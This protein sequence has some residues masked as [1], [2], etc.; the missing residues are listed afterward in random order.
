MNTKRVHRTGHVAAL[1]WLLVALGATDVAAQ[2]SIDVHD[3]SRVRFSRADCSSEEE[4]WLDLDVSGLSGALYRSTEQ[5]MLQGRST[6]GGVVC[7]DPFIEAALST[8]FPTTDLTPNVGADRYLDY[9]TLTAAD[10]LGDETCGDVGAR[11]TN[12][13]LCW[14]ILD[15]NLDRVVTSNGIALS[16]DTALPVAPLLEDVLAE[17]GQV[18]FTLRDPADQG[19]AFQARVQYRPCAAFDG[20]P[21]VDAGGDDA[22]RVTD[23]GDA[24]VSACESPNA[25]AELT[26]DSLSVVIGDLQNGSSYEFRARLEDDFGNVGPFSSAIV[27]T[28][29]AQLGVL[30]FYDGEGSPFSLRPACA[31][32]SLRDVSWLGLVVVLGL[33]RALRRRRRMSL[34]RGAGW[35]IGVISIVCVAPAAQARPGGWNVGIHVGPYQPAIDDEKVSDDNIFPV[36][37]CFFDDAVLAELGFQVGVTLF[38]A[39]GS[40]EFGVHSSF[41][42]A[43]G[44]GQSLSSIDATTG[45]KVCGTSTEGSVEL[46]IVKLRPGLTYRFDYFLDAAGFPV[47][48]YGRAGVVAAG[49]G[50]S[51][52]GVFDDTVTTQ[53]VDPLGVVFGLEGAL[54][55]QLALDFLD[56]IDPFTPRTAQRARTNGVFE[57][58]FVYGELVFQDIRNLGQ[59]GFVFSPRDTVFSTGL[60]VMAQVGLALELP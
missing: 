41:S 56:P 35:W 45:T 30:D 1:G 13:A 26:F 33:G 24:D 43:R 18:S 25:Y 29:R 3:L 51:S 57:H 58:A 48:P 34:G 17:A 54:G 11:E 5:I 12:A 15:A 32:V 22:G 2:V 36:Y 55:V 47:V 52:E 44:N 9:I 7:P 21:V 50:F 23:D 59:P 42:Q 53:S 10:L 39:I 19:D 14:Y 31:S 37:A 28:P 20:G 16:Y 27:V 60:P 6:A 40:L 38:D 49:Y 46:T 8:V 4:L